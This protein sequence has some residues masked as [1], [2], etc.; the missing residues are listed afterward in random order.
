M[1]AVQRRAAA[2]VPF[3]LGVTPDA[4]KGEAWRRTVGWSYPLVVV[5]APPTAAP[6]GGSKRRK[7]AGYPRRVVIDGRVYWVSNAEEERELLEAYLSSLEADAIEAA[8]THGMDSTPVKRLRIKI[9][10]TVARLGET[11][12]R[13]LAWEKFLDDEDEE[14]LMLLH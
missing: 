3:G 8:M 11:A 14:L 7:Y 6:G 9:K 5:D 12:N 2:G 13:A 10:R 1:N 4:A